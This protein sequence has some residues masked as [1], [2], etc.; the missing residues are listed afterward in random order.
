MLA[1]VVPS[2]LVHD[3]LRAYRW[4][5]D[6]SGLVW[7]A[8]FIGCLR[9]VDGKVVGAW[10]YDHHQGVSCHMHIA[11]EPRGLN[12]GALHHM[13]AVPFQQW[14]YACVL[15]IIPRGNVKSANL[16]QKLGFTRFAELPDA[17]PTGAIDFFRMNANEC[18][19]LK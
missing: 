15:G 5:A 9:E 18:K 8:D 4:I 10:G 11:V 6:R 17:H 14:R 12:R 16:A 13:F 1:S 7:V 2:S 3:D 19:W